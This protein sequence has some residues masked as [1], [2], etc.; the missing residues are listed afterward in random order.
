M[1]LSQHPLAPLT[2]V[3]THTKTPTD[4]RGR[5]PHPKGPRQ[6]LSTTNRLDRRIPLPPSWYYT[7]KNATPKPRRVRI[8]PEPLWTLTAPPPDDESG[9][10]DAA[11]RVRRSKLVDSKL[12]AVQEAGIDVQFPSSASSHDSA[13]S[14]G[15]AARRRAIRGLP[16]PA[17]FLEE[18]R[19]RRRAPP[20]LPPP[21]PEFPLPPSVIEDLGSAAREEVLGD[22]A[23]QA[24]LTHWESVVRDAPGGSGYK[25]TG[26]RLFELVKASVEG[27]SMAERRRK[28]SLNGENSEDVGGDEE[29]V[30]GQRGEEKGDWSE[31][32]CTVPEEMELN[33][34]VGPLKWAYLSRSQK[35]LWDRIAREDVQAHLEKMRLDPTHGT[36]KDGCGCQPRYRGGDLGGIA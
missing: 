34:P 4:A 8:P 25:V 36:A 30:H 18:S 14:T 19:R 7:T 13:N 12:R 33:L 23:Y 32:T 26:E 17:V 15:E 3:L 35:I 6:P 31:E 27:V 5:P 20:L 10:G 9:S 21:A 1:I 29:D 24:L 28:K 11:T 2:P 22:P 16:E